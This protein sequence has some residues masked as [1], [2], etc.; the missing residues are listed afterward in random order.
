MRMT[1]TLLGAVLLANSVAAGFL[2]STNVPSAR[3]YREREVDRKK[4]VEEHRPPSASAD[5]NQPPQT[6]RND[7]TDA[8]EQEVDPPPSK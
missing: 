7:E 3:T 2:D 1:R 5:E 8:N 4:K 6:E